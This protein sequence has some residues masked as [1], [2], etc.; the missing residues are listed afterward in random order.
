MALRGQSKMLRSLLGVG[1]LFVAGN[2]LAGWGELNMT[3]GVTPI[4]REAYDLHMIVLW[5]CVWIGVLVFGV[6][7]YSIY[8]HRK[9]RGVEAAHFHHSTAAEI[10]WSII[11]F[12]ILVAMA[13]PAT[14][15]LI[16]ME[17]S[18]DPDLTIKV[19][20]Y[21]WKWRYEYVDDGV[22][23][24]S[25]LA[26]ESRA[27]IYGDPT[28]VDNYMLDVD[29]PIVVPVNKKVRF[30][31]TSDD[32]IH[33]W[34]VP[35]LGMKRDAIPGFVNE[36]WAKIDTAG[37]YRGQCAELCG[38]EHG[39]M[40][41][42][43]I[44]KEQE[45]YEQWLAARQSDQAT[46]VAEAAREWRKG[47]LIAKG[48]AVYNTTCAA[49]HQA[50]GEG[51]PGTFPSIKGSEVATGP[52]DKHLDV[53]LNGKPGTAMQAFGTQLSDVE[54]AAV[55]TYQRNAL[56]NDKGDVVQPAGVTVARF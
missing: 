44:A 21:Q 11:P 43:V 16:M 31:L 8:N 23:F 13:V 36:M 12:V 48:E 27:A 30:L 4:S 40:P 34:W 15:A 2:A 28:N 55:L 17:D 18:S 14:K 26:S 24:Y 29:K 53:V 54:I 50:N 9:S 39:F 35:A 6:M 51:I 47:E 22:S 1:L 45:E 49:C 7:F 38:R 5:I 10:V 46:A 37:V 56:G 42:V 20:G 19:T 33:A 32:V 3:E 41:I 25:S 52:V